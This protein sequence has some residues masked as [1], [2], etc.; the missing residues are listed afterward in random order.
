MKS[1]VIKHSGL[2]IIQSLFVFI[3][4]FMLLLYFSSIPASY[5]SIDVSITRYVATNG[6]DSGDCSTV[7][8]PCRTI[9]YAVNKS[10]STDR[11]LVSA[12]TYTY[13]AAT[14][15]CSFLR[16][17]AVVCF[18]D[19]NLTIL[20]G[21]STNNWSVQKP[22]EN[23]TI[24]DGQNNYRG[25]V[26]VGY[27]TTTAHLRMEGF[28][29][30]NGRTVGPTY[31][32]CPCAMGGGMLVQ[33]AAITL[34]DMI[35]S[36]NQAIGANTSSGDGGHADGGAIRIESSP[37][38]TNSLLQRVT[39][40]NNQSYGGTGPDRGGVAFGALFIYG[41]TVTVEDS[42]FTNN[43][44]R[45]GS[46]S[47]SGTSRVDGLN[48][49]ALGGGIAVENGAI[50][51]RRIIVTGNQVQ[52][53]NARDN[54][55]G[56]FGAGIFVE[57][58]SSYTSSLSLSDSIV[59]NNQ[60]TAGN[61]ARGGNAAGGGI[62][63]VNSYVDIQRVKIDSNSAIGGSTTGAG[64]AG[65]GA[66]GG[67]YVFAVR[68][69]VPRATIKNVVVARNFA[70]QGSGIASLGNGGGGGIVVHGMGADIIHTTI[71]QNRIGSYLV[72]G[73]GLLVQPWALQSGSLPAAVNLN[74]SIV[75]DHTQ[76]NSAMSAVVVQVGSTLTLNRNLFAGNRE[77]TN[78]NHVPVQPGT[79]NGMATTLYAVE[80]GFMSLNIPSSDFHIRL[81]SAAKDQAVGSSTVEDIDGKSRTCS[82]GCDLGAHEYS[83][84]P[85][86]FI[87][88]DEI[89]FL[90]WTGI[91]DTV[92]DL[93]GYEV[94][95]SCSA[96]GNPPIQGDC[97]QP[98]DVGAATSTTLTG[99]TN[100]K[101]YTLLVNALDTD[102]NLM[103]TSTTV[104]AIPGNISIFLPLLT[105]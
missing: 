18:V 78:V 54:A 61:A 86:N 21:F 71:A 97:D 76:G 13:N 15:Q 39:F 53:G 93:R 59:A 4:F 77:D 14:D 75:A 27:N 57:G 19:K 24:I 50:T 23:P 91:T 90:D 63:V 11:I 81:D 84:F 47:G 3:V 92:G 46:S 9:Q 66:G 31:T 80:P 101:Q 12:G 29:V 85:L 60:A 40:D 10:A 55:G 5:A 45:G 73:G 102:Q 16:T 95:V 6:N 94:Y 41:S 82:N 69:G 100:S 49:D 22:L 64:N 58:V 72:L 103:A 30:M 99:L 1:L 98:I 8:A 104:I 83:P 67:I 70:D 25:V 105:K 48:A 51:V 88:G 87:S 7:S 37:A 38:G 79:I 35:F 2:S 74:Y 34:R 20:G 52:G 33:K 28:T 42:V 65:T 32:N 26:A 62:D 96:G 56:A 43:L 89:L 17:R 36:N 68:S 44:A